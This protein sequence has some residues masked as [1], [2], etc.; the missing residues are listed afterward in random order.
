M[1][2]KELCAIA[3]MKTPTFNSHR[4]NGDLPFRIERAE[5][6]DAEGRTWSHFTTHH[7]ARMLAA[8]HLVDAHRVLWSEAARMLREDA[9]ACGAFGHGHRYFDRDGIFIAQVEFANTRTN[10]EPTLFPARKTYEGPLDSIIAAAMGEAAAYSARP[11]V[12]EEIRVVSIVS[13]DLSHHYRLARGIAEQLGIDVQADYA[14]EP[15]EDRAE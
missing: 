3:G 6:Q 5:G 9:T 8:R 1:I 2:R 14:V 13:V 11:E 12:R 7:A 4:M 10:E 15:G